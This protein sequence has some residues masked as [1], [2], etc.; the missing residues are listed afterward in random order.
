MQFVINLVIRYKKYTFQDLYESYFYI[1]ENI[2]YIIED[3]LQLSNRLFTV[4]PDIFMREMLTLPLC[5]AT[6]YTPS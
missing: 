5:G 6:R 4:S 3:I 1:G 2:S